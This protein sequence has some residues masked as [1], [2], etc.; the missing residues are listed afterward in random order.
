MR[1]KQAI[2]AV[3]CASQKITFLMRCTCTAMCAP[4]EEIHCDVGHDATS[5][6]AWRRDVM[7]LARD[8][9]LNVIFSV[10]ISSQL[11]S[12][13]S[14]PHMQQT[15]NQFAAIVAWYFAN[16]FQRP[17]WF[18]YI[19]LGLELRNA[20][21]KSVAINR[22][23]THSSVRLSHMWCDAAQVP[24]CLCSMTACDKRCPESMSSLTC[25]GA[26]LFCTISCVIFVLD[27]PFIVTSDPLAWQLDR[28]VPGKTLAERYGKQCYD[29]RENCLGFI[30]ASFNLVYGPCWQAALLT[31]F[32][33]LLGGVSCSLWEKHSSGRT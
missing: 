15:W 16:L 6:R 8:L 32:P 23:I 13:L 30:I 31:L 1:P 7:N 33:R 20:E 12:S 27:R 29:C 24:W 11:I 26:M 18:Q 2:C 19:G 10:A 14:L 22:N 17:T 3:P 4:A 25:I 28:H 9:F 21:D 5:L